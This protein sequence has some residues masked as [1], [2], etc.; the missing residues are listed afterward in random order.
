M[1]NI[2]IKPFAFILLILFF[3]CGFDRVYN[4]RFFRYKIKYPV[5]WIAVNSGH[6]KEAEKKFKERLIRESPLQ[7][8]EKANVAFYNPESQPPIFEQITVVSHQD[9]FDVKHLEALI[10]ELENIFILQ[11]SQ[12]FS[13][14]RLIQSDIEN[15]KDGKI[16]RFEF[17]FNY[18]G[19]EYFDTYVIIPGR[20]FS[21]S[22]LNGISESNNRITFLNTF[23]EVLNSFTKY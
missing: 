6:N 5:G 2:K 22:Y 8:Y 11:L 14:V 1:K 23:N 3:N 16:L 18:N 7:N 10:P 4:N 13:S 20:L 9:R 12:T 21:T 15:F 19:K 17:F